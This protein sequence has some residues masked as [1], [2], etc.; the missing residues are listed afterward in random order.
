M[1][2][3]ARRRVAR[4]RCLLASVALLGCALAAATFPDA[5]SAARTLP[6]DASFG[7]LTAFAYPYA[8]IGGKTWR[9]SP[10]AKIYNEQNLIIMPAAMRQRA[11]VLYR[12]DSAGSLSG[13]WLLTESEAAAFERRAPGTKPSAGT[14][15]GAGTRP[16]AGT[17]PAG[18]AQ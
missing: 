7:K 8:S 3:A 12:L 17:T 1:L 18:G 10:G 11:K 9:M 5:A 2:G 15:P 16:S 6:K 4:L 13:I 14:K